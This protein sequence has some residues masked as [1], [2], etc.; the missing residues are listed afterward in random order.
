MKQ[1][2]K[3]LGKWLADDLGLEFNPFDLKYLDAGADPRLPD[4]LIG[5]ESFEKIKGDWP[6]FV[7]AMAGGGKSA[8]RVRLARAC[9]VGQEG[10]RVLPVVYKVPGP[11][12]F[13]DSPPRLEGHLKFLCWG[14]ASELLL[15]LASRPPRYL[16]LDLETRREVRLQLEANLPGELGYFLDKLEKTGDI[17][18]LVNRFDPTARHLLKLPEPPDIRPFCD[19]MREASGEMPREPGGPAARFQKLADLV[20]GPLGYEAIY[21]LV[22]G[23]DAHIEVIKD[24]HAGID[25]IRALLKQT[26][27]WT[28]K[29]IYAKY[30]LPPEFEVPIKKLSF[31]PTET[32]FVSIRWTT[33]MLV[34]MLQERLKIA[35][36]NMFGS[37]DAISN[38]ELR[39][40]EY[41]LVNMAEESLPREV[42]LLA[43]QMLRLHVRQFGPSGKLRLADF[44]AIRD[45]YPHHSRGP[46]NP[47]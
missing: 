18:S 10:R 32:R 6:A 1:G 22:D 13:A 34:D 16:G 41:E 4:Y 29:R 33:D 3:G 17:S 25:L 35:S 47:Q 8:F 2:V 44:N 27:A 24:P 14:M 30:F 31:L 7:F 43:G 46:H 26:G 42:L 9:R 5:H 40:V 11:V 20:R 45:W 36:G 39:R 38:P 28:E 15:E 21:L 23:V 12:N 19:A 37:F